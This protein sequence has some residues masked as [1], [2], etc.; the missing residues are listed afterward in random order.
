MHLPYGHGHVEL[1]GELVATI[2]FPPPAPRPIDLL[3]RALRDAP[4]LDGDPLIVVSDITRP[5][6]TRAMV[7]ALMRRYGWEPEQLT[8]LAATG[9]HPGHTAADWEG[10]LGSELATRVTLLNNDAFD[11]RHINVGTTARGTPAA[12]HPAYLDAEVRITTGLVEFH[13]FAGFSGGPKAL[14]PGISTQAAIEANHRWALEP[15]AVPGALKGSRVAE[16]IMEAATLAP[17]SLE[18]NVALD[19]GGVCGAAA[20]MLGTAR[21]ACI[22]PY[23]ASHTVEIPALAD[24]TVVS[25]GGHP[26]DIDFRQASKALDFAQHATRP[27]G[28]LILLAECPLGMGDP[29]LGRF[30]RTGW[31]D[32]LEQQR[33]RFELG[34]QRATHVL[35]IASR[36]RIIMVTAMPPE[37]FRET[38]LEAVE[39]L[40][41]ALAMAG[42]GTRSGMAYGSLWPRLSD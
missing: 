14:M 15:D 22:A 32:L 27:G 26:R 9:N 28:T 24:I 23:T 12:Y 21:D 31:P 10:L 16:D 1:V 42:A 35:E 11:D 6:P 36:Y 39:S 18:F 34:S 41:A 13:P 40:D 19:A 17:P 33:Q 8:L 25:A 29:R 7:E 37:A 3:D 2:D 38:P 4:A 5:T 30:L 20:G